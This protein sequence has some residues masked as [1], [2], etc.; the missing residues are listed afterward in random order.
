[1]L[2]SSA[3]GPAG[4]RRRIA[5]L[6]GALLSVG[7]VMVLSAAPA[8]AGRLIATGHDADDHCDPPDPAQCHWFDVALDY[9]RGGAPEPNNRVL[10][11]DCSGSVKTAIQ[12]TYPSGGPKTKFVCPSDDPDAFNGVDIKVNKFSALVVG[13]SCDDS[14]S[15]G[16]G[17]DSLNLTED[18]PG[19]C[20]EPGGS[21]P[22]SDLI[23]AR[24]SDIKKFFNK[25]GGVIALAGAENGDGDPFDGPDNYYD[26]L[27]LDAQGVNVS[28]PFCLTN[29]GIQIG[30]ED[31]LCPDPAKHNGTHNDINCC[32]T[33][34]SFAEPAKGEALKV[35]ERDSEGFAETLVADA[36]IRGGGFVDDD[37]DEDKP[38][39]RSKGRRQAEGNAGCVEENFRLRVIVHDES[40][41]RKVKVTLDG[42]KLKSTKRNRF[43]VQVPAKRQLSGPHELKITARDSEGNRATQ[44][45]PF[46]RCAR[47][48]PAFTG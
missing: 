23:N 37:A 17:D 10:L 18:L 8:D 31:Q 47:E 19:G 48:E 34:N 28:P 44:R 43:S 32:E 24:K 15:D 40:K 14:D 38:R 41:L 4:L 29:R 2:D 7:A 25:G 3:V 20:D 21:T 26:F 46:R 39:I 22:D 30:W 35:A 1:M 5:I 13:S 16:F 33:H 9:V 11:L 42:R 45:K 12:G 27:P 36:K 6:I